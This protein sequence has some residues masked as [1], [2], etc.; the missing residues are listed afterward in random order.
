MSKHQQIQNSAVTVLVLWHRRSD[1]SFVSAAG[2]VGVPRPP[3]AGRADLTVK[4][5]QQRAEHG[6]MEHPA[7]LI[8]P[9][10]FLLPQT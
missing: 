5:S 10:M 6:N 7:P 4:P 1:P 3:G 8:K 2:H 9:L